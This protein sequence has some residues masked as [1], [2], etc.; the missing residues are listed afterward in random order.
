MAW[1]ARC[2]FN[3]GGNHGSFFRISTHLTLLFAGGERTGIPRGLAV[4]EPYDSLNFVPTV[5]ALTGDL[6]RDN[7]PDAALS[8][9]GF[10]KFPGRVIS[11][12]AGQQFKPGSSVS[13]Q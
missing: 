7:T 3:P 4:A 8:N 12:V 11:E 1:H 10:L 5:L 6:Q 2:S 13:A 9:R